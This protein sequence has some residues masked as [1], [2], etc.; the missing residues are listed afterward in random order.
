MMLQLSLQIFIGG[1]AE[2]EQPML[3]IV[4][5]KVFSANNG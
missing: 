4:S 2:L 1:R 3:K 5:S